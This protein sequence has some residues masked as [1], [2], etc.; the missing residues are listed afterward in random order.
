MKLLS[1]IFFILGLI[2]PNSF[3]SH[4]HKA[5]PKKSI[6]MLIIQTLLI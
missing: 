2:V 4:S 1:I 3:Y 6:Q 5:E